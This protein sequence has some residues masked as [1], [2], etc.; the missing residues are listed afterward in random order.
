MIV[1]FVDGKEQVHEADSAVADDFL[2]VLY[3]YGAG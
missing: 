1:K 2:F 3:K